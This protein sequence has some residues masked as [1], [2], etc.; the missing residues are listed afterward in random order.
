MLGQRCFATQH[1][2]YQQSHYLFKINRMENTSL[3]MGTTLRWRCLEGLCNFNCVYAIRSSPPRILPLPNSDEEKKEEG[4]GYR[5]QAGC[6]TCRRR[7][8]QT[9]EEKR[10]GDIGKIGDEL[11]NQTIVFN[12][13]MYPI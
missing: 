8:G 2:Y 6:I 1:F 9:I 7:R 3:I 12:I 5:V 13:P 10:G 11:T 4:G